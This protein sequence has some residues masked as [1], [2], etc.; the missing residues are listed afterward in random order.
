MLVPTSLRTWALQQPSRALATPARQSRSRGVG[1]TGMVELSS[2]HPNGAVGRPSVDGPTLPGDGR[3]KLAFA[4]RGPCLGRDATIGDGLL[5][6]QA[7]LGEV[8][9]VRD[10]VFD[11]HA[12]GGRVK[13]FVEPDP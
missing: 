3:K 11:A 10:Q 9:A 6:P 5:D 12:V 8:D 2:H 1:L 13:G 7:D 4:E